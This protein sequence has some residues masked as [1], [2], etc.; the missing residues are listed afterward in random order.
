M[1]LS[2]LAVSS[3]RVQVVVQSPSPVGTVCIASASSTLCP[4]SP[5][6]ITSEV[7][8]KIQV[9][10]S[11]QNSSIFN[12]FDVLVKADPSIINATGFDLSATVLSNPIIGTACIN[13]RL[14]AGSQSCYAQDGPGV[15]H[16]FVAAGCAGV[17]LACGF[18]TGNLFNINY[19]V[20][21]S[22]MGSPIDFQT[23]CYG[24]PPGT[25]CVTIQFVPA[26][27]LCCPPPDLEN[28]QTG[29]FV[30]GAS[31]GNGIPVAATVG[32]DG[33][34]AR[35]VGNILVNSTARTL[36]GSLSVTVVNDTSGQT[37]FSKTLTIVSTRILRSDSLFIFI[38][39]IPV[40]PFTLG[41]IGTVNSATN[42]VSFV[43]MRTPDFTHAGIVNIV[44]ATDVFF[45]FG[46]TKLFPGFLPQADLDG[47]GIINLF[48][49]TTVSYCF[50]ALVFS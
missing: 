8:N 26:N 10:V 46:W 24:G 47:D 40:S 16:L 39:A 6:V 2:P 29:T 4:A 18:G 36:L 45:E 13:G 7:G 17:T 9:A 30:T 21:G 41:A 25:P 42:Q 19:T 49:A 22:T 34:T 12:E 37:I 15:A 50:N 27:I 35:I 5:A 31:G 38:L 23:G 1:L 33:L 44:D 3:P 48:D 43:L 28:L 11:I 32:F 20:V 14:I